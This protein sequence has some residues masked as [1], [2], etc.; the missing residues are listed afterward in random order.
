MHYFNS[1]F[2]LMFRFG[3]GSLKNVMLVLGYKRKSTEGIQEQ[4]GNINV[5]LHAEETVA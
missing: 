2:F 3:K 5:M 4:K 1:I